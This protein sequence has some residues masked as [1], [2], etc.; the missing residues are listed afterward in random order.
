MN[1]KGLTMIELL[2]ALS[3]SGILLAGIY[4]TFVSQ[5][6]TFVSQDQLVDMQ[7]NVRLAI[8]KMTREI[9]MA[10]FGGGGVSSWDASEFFLHGAIYGAYTGVVT[11]GGG[12][13]S[14]TVVE[15]FQLLIPTTLSAGAGSGDNKIFVSDVSSFDTAPN[16]RRYISI[17]GTESHEINS[18][19]AG[20]KELQF[21]GWD[22]L[23]NDH[24]AGEPIYL[25]GAV[26]YS[27]GMFEGKSCLMRD[28]HL[29]GLGQP[30]AENVESLQFRYFDANGIE[31]ANPKDIRMIQVTIVA[32]S[33]QVDP[34]L[35]KV[36]DG[37][38]RRTMISNIQ[39]RN[40]NF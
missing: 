14:V 5:Q 28:D 20:T 30:V 37:F 23:V 4:R 26:T 39:L 16:P 15:G 40:L 8:N 24:Q 10:G 1:R 7:Q 17:N 12:G 35:A 18:I 11:P 31:T 32:R 27:I 29:G 25:V 13:T 36:G 22:K 19:N 33:D 2:V 38:R 3:V 6:N 9:R 21:H 34:K